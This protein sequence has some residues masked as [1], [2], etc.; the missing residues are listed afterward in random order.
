MLTLTPKTQKLLHLT[1]PGLVIKIEMLFSG[2]VRAAK[3]MA[4]KTQSRPPPTGIPVS[5]GTLRIF[6]AV[7]ST[8][9]NSNS[10]VPD[11]T[12]AN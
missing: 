8:T 5:E 6:V 4:A 2:I 9:K 7:V 3:V 10:I 1:A 12:C 11:K